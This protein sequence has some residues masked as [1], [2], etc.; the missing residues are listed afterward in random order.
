MSDSKELT[1]TNQFAVMPVME[2]A[3]AVSRYQSLVKFT[4]QIMTENIDFGA[5]P[6][7]D[8]PTLLKP[9][10]E[11]L[12]NFF[13]LTPVFEP[14]EII[15]DWTGQDHGEP[16]FEFQYKCKLYRDKRLVSEGIGSCNSWEKKYRYRWVDESEL[17]IHLDP[18]DLTRRKS[19]IVEFQFAINKHEISGKYGKPAEYWE[20]FETA[21]AAGDARQTIRKTAA[22]KE[23]DAWE[24][25]TIVYR[26]PNEDIFSQVNTL[27]K[28]AQKRALIAAVL[29]GVNASEFFT[30]DLEDTEILTSEA[31]I[32]DNQV[33]QTH[34]S[35]T[36]RNRTAIE[37]LLMQDDI[38]IEV[39]FSACGVGGW[40]KMTEFEGT[41]KEAFYLA[42]THLK[43]MTD[44]PEKLH[45]S[46]IA[47]NRDGIEGLL[48]KNGIPFD[49]I[50]NACKI[51]K[52]ED[53]SDLDLTGQ[54]VFNLSRDWWINHSVPV[55][56]RKEL[57]EIEP[58]AS[59]PPDEMPF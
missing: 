3:T 4:Q 28:M 47:K 5:I 16:F 18:D 20:S 32:E 38:S 35:L 41:G 34:W 45:W 33:F 19:S 24:I 26:I 53:L 46:Q 59:D 1:T 58:E 27:D 48:A 42:K 54:E 37:A 49:A 56:T 40:D 52:W 21:I 30:Q 10:A 31:V 57:D 39:L 14:I 55:N 11:K 25:E 22:G 8:K 17:P 15:K 43:D 13:G 36:V 2:I 23:L 6:G 50:L 44:S 9:G 7:T 51:E 29:I 12:V